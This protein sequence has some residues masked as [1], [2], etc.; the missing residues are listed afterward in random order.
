MVAKIER[1]RVSH[2]VINTLRKRTGRKVLAN[3]NRDTGARW[4]G[5]T[6]PLVLSLSAVAAFKYPGHG[7]A[8][9][10]L[11]RGA[12]AAGAVASWATQLF[13]RP[14]QLSWGATDTELRHHMP[15]DALVEHP[16]L[17]ATRALTIDAPAR[18]IWPWMKELDVLPASLRGQRVV[19]QMDH[20]RTVVRS[21]REGERPQAT[22]SM[23]LEVLSEAHTRLVIRL[24]VAAPL[25]ARTLLSYVLVDRDFAQT[26]AR[27]TEVKQR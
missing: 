6:V 5:L 23:H 10:K 11:L 22:A 13:V 24:R 25:A 15:G 19:E 16:W 21:I 4:P 12:M 26:R 7:G 17:E 2:K 18:V 27:M 8:P 1:R 20:R 9:L 14:W 3:A